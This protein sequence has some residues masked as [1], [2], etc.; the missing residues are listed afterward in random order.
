MRYLVLVVFLFFFV[1]ACGDSAL[2]VGKQEYG[3][4]WPFVNFDNGRLSCKKKSFGGTVRPLVLIELG[5]TVY[6][7][8]GV[9]M[10]VGGFPD[11][12]SQMARHPQFEHIILGATDK[13]IQRGLKMCNL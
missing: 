13:L 5:G 4:E 6:G 10:G 9:A 1:T 3:D 8:N 7:L 12:K 11:A 2:T